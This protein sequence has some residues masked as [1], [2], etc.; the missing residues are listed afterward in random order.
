MKTFKKE[1]RLEEIHYRY[2]QLRNFFRD[3]V[4]DDVNLFYQQQGS[5]LKIY[6]DINYSFIRIV[7]SILILQSGICEISVHHKITYYTSLVP[8]VWSIVQ[9]STKG[10]ISEKIRRFSCENLLK[11]VF[12][13]NQLRI[14]KLESFIKL[15]TNCFHFFFM[16]NILNF[17]ISR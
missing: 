7:Q 9:T 6:L 11:I 4:L 1:Y 3:Y 17:V 16:C 10:K 8:L 12:V 15:C 5:I 2:F 13:D 14:K